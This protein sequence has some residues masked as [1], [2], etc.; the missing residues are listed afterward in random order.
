MENSKVDGHVSLI[1]D[2]QSNAILNTNSIEYNNYIS[3]KRQKES[4]AVKLN[5]LQ[6]EV[7]SLRKELNELKTLV[8]DLV[9]E[10]RS[11]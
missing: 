5:N 10:I 7:E 4:E 1:R 8:R 2:N 6:S 3:I 9:N 11:R